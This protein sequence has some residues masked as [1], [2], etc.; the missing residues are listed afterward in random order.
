MDCAGG[1]SPL[2]RGTLFMVFC[3]SVSGGLIPARAGNIPSSDSP[4]L[5][6]EAHPRS[7]GEHQM[8]PLA[9][10]TPEGSSPLARGTFS[11]L[12]AAP[13]HER[14]IPARA[15]NILADKARYPAKPSKIFGFHTYIMGRVDERSSTVTRHRR[16][17]SY[18]LSSSRVQKIRNTDIQKSV[19]LYAP[20]CIRGYLPQD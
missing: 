5:L 12:S 4:G 6:R 15:G 13:S 18:C 20:P 10:S 11:T 3:I 2:A 7:R 8:E 9:P 17:R 14:L 1:S 16:L 19:F